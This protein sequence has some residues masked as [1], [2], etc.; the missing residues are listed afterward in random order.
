MGGIAYSVPQL[1]SGMFY[2]HSLG[3]RK[4]NVGKQREKHETFPE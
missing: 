4:E 1:L 3:T 2:S